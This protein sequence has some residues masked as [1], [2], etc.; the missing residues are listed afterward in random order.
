MRRYGNYCIYIKEKG[1]KA[2]HFYRNQEGIGWYSELQ[3]AQDE[4]N[5][6]YTGEQE[7]T[8]R[9]KWVNEKGYTGK[10][11]IFTYPII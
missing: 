9:Q 2:A 1:K 6:I 7:V 8:I 3:E 10:E 5:S 11:N 4:A